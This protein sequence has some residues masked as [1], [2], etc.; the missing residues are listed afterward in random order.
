MGSLHILNFFNIKDIKT[1]FTKTNVP[2]KVLL[3]GFTI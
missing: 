3:C 1:Y 2:G